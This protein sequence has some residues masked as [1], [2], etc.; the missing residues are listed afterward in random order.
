M[1]TISSRTLYM[2]RATNDDL[3]PGRVL[4]TDRLSEVTWTDRCPRISADRCP[5]RGRRRTVGFL[6]IANR[7]VQPHPDDLARLLELPR[8]YW[9]HDPEAAR[10]ALERWQ[11][12]LSKGGMDP[13]R[14]AGAV[15]QPRTF[16]YELTIA[17]PYRI[18]RF[19]P[20]A[21]PGAD[22]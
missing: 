12:E 20:S 8:P 9:T 10:R 6:A 2:V 15:F 11:D 4:E 13:V 22:A 14:L 3:L 18:R 16:A 7:T 17:D 19:R 21:R 1:G 5:S